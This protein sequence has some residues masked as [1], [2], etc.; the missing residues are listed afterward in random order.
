MNILYISLSPFESIY[1]SSFRNRS[2]LKGLL[3]NNYN[4]DFLTIENSNSKVS[5]EILNSLKGINIIKLNKSNNSISDHLVEKTIIYNSIFT[6]FIKFIYHSFFIYDFTYYKLKNSNLISHLP[7]LNYDYLITSSDPVSSHKLGTILIRNGL[8]YK[9]WIQYWGDPYASDITKNLLYP[10][11]IKKCIEFQLL[12]KADSV[13]YTSPF[14]LDAQKSLF[15]TISNKMKFLPTPYFKE[16][17]YPANNN[18]FYK[19]GYFGNY[20]SYTRDIMPLY[21]SIDILDSKIQLL[22]IGGADLELQSKQNVIIKNQTSN[23]SEYESDIDLNI[24]IL[25]KKGTQIPGKLYHLAG[26]NKPILVILDG[27]EI[28]KMKVFLNSLNRYELCENNI[29]DI[30][31]AIIR[32]KNKPFS[33]VPSNDLSTKFISNKL[34][35]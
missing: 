18:S 4:V 8:I 11:H 20:H 33:Y 34:L 1:S 28:N 14:T 27:I 2:I 12:K 17:I 9:K 24:V 21:N 23:I 25:N 13:I 30:A 19:I 35:S 3:E 10:L 6:K 5:D 32:I 16:V 26:T 31:N 29:N 7:T 15:K 22:I